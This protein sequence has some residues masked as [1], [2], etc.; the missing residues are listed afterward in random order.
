MPETELR[1]GKVSKQFALT[2]SD[3]DCGKL[4]VPVPD[5]EVLMSDPP[6]LDSPRQTST[7]SPPD[8]SRRSVLKLLGVAG[9]AT[10]FGRALSSVVGE[11]GSITE[12]MIEQAEWVAGI[13]L[14]DE[15]RQLML[16]GAKGLLEKFREDPGGRDRQRHPSGPA[17]HTAGLQPRDRPAAWLGGSCDRV[18]G[19]DAPNRR[20]HS[21]LPA[22]QRAVRV[23]PFSTGFLG[24]VDRVLPGPSGTIRRT[25]RMR[26]H[27][28]ARTGD[29]A[30]PTC[31]PGA[32]R[33]R[34]SW[35]PARDSLGSQG[36]SCRAGVSDDLGSEAVRGP[37]SAGSGHGRFKARRCR[38]GPGSQVDAGGAGVG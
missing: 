15:E 33:R 26:D 25:P 2:L 24:G 11:D 19:S 1:T 27:A 12:G 3:L 7:A 18:R 17:L 34:L 35:A 4:S 32:V 6:R 16:D 21:G 14:S 31:R 5:P 20:R 22:R 28:D 38:C 13:R 9:S 30:G 36:S 37:G 8:R 29:R 23:D 10:V